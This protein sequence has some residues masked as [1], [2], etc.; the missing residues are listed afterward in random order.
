[1]ITYVHIHLYKLRGEAPTRA[2]KQINIIIMINTI[3]IVVSSTSSSSTAS[4]QSS[5]SS[6]IH[7][8]EA[9]IA[10]ARLTSFA[11]VSSTYID[12]PTLRGKLAQ[13]EALSIT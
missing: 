2:R 1:M 10:I 4:S 7:F 3:I 12:V 11:S 8:L 5:S 9:A 6:S 13:G